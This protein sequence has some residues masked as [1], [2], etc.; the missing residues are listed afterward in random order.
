MEKKVG[1]MPK[2]YLIFSIFFTTTAIS[3]SQELQKDS[4]S[5]MEDSSSVVIKEHSKN[6]Y[7]GKPLIMSSRLPLAQSF[8][9][10]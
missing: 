8:C 9:F 2:F 6:I 3:Y 5:K 4:S 7:P 1:R 10:L